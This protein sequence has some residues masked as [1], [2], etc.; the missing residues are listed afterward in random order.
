MEPGA[1]K[2]ITAGVTAPETA[3][4]RVKLDTGMSDSERLLKQD[5]REIDL[6]STVERGLEECRNGTWETGLALLHKVAR[7]EGRQERLPSVYYSYLGYG[8]ARFDNE[9]RDGLALCRR[10]VSMDPDERENYLNLARV[11]LLIGN[12]RQAVAAVQRGLRIDATFVPLLALRAGMG[13]R[14]KPV[15]GLLS[16]GHWLNR[17]LGRRR[18]RRLEAEEKRI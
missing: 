4:S 2:S 1:L 18:H 6:R 7:K 14:R 5:T 13:Y 8:A 3:T 12:R 17:W 9:R 11:C 15:V 10:A 16:R